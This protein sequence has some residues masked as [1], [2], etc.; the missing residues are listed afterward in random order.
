MVLLLL[1]VVP[2]FKL[3]GIMLPFFR[4][5]ELS[6]FRVDIL[7][8]ASGRSLDLIDEEFD[9]NTTTLTLLFLFNLTQLAYAFCFSF[10]FLELSDWPRNSEKN[11]RFLAVWWA[12]LFSMFRQYS[13][14]PLATL[15]L[16]FN[17]EIVSNEL[18]RIDLFKVSICL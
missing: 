15:L 4:L 2:L 7:C 6:F 12:E 17:V 8:F 18:L 1:S 10:S 16:L 13:G 5:H 14:I 9:L 11:R 3:Y